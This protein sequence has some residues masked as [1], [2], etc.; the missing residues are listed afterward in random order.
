MECF[1]KQLTAVR[2]KCDFFNVRLIFNPE[3]FIRYKNVVEPGSKSPHT[4]FL[5]L[6]YLIIYF[7][8][9]TLQNLQ[10]TVYFLSSL[11]ISLKG[12]ENL[13]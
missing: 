2:I 7:Q 11:F 5:V 1:K 3:I 12:T 13:W 9:R 6:F 10:K 8:V 4:Y